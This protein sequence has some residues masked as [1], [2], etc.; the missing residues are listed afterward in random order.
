MFD[1]VPFFNRFRN[2]A[3]IVYIMMMAFIMVTMIGTNGIIS[4]GKIKEYFSNKYIITVISIIILLFLIVYS[5]MLL[6]VYV[7]Q[8]PQV[9]SFVKSQ[10]LIFLIFILMFVL[11]FYLFSNNKIKFNT[12]GVLLSIIL[13]FEI[14]FIWFDQ[15]NG[16]KNPE[17]VFT[18]RSQ[19]AEKF[20]QEM[21]DEIFRVNSRD[22]GYMLF[23]RNQGFVDNIE[24]LE[25]YGALLLK[26]F[27]PPNGSDPKSSQTHDLMNVKYKIFT[28]ST[29]K[30]KTLGLN[31]NYLPR[32][33][34]FYDAVKF[35][36]SEEVKNY[37]MTNNFNYRRTLVIEEKENINLPKLNPLD[38][39][40]ANTVK[41]LE[42]TL[43]TMKVEV[44][45]PEDGI[46]YFSEVYYPAFKSYLDGQPVKILKADYCMRSVIVPKGK[47]IVEMKYESD[48]FNTGLIFTL[49]TLGLFFISL[50]ISFIISRKKKSK[51][52]NEDS[53]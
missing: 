37:M 22:G 35:D 11:S 25:G 40:P 10:G 13:L 15:N 32:V 50:P 31:S 46:L 24:F 21:K 39:V 7:A 12:F 47:H 29:G 20:K 51:K 26:N 8:V 30:G 36:S 9:S 3:H 28:D 16:T 53:D 18:Q 52:E 38:S 48:S 44:N 17:Q 34:M 6:P 4:E 23:Q 45:T 19:L 41:I 33:M 27:I 5:G 14:Y 42:H 49:S 43:N 1:I 2:P